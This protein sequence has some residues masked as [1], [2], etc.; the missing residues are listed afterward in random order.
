MPTDCTSESTW[1]YCYLISTLKCN[2]EAQG[3]L[4]SVLYTCESPIARAP[5]F[6]EL[7]Y[8]LPH[9]RWDWPLHQVAHERGVFEEIC[10]R[11]CLALSPER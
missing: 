3:D 2:T 5:L 11:Q 8:D 9:L 6:L 7:A 1:W 4:H 10:R